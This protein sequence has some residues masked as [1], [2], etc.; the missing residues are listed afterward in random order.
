MIVALQLGRLTGAC[1]GPKLAA[2]LQ[3]TSGFQLVAGD[4]CQISVEFQDFARLDDL[5]SVGHDG[6]RCLGVGAVE[7]FLFRERM[8]GA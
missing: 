5:V 1:Q 2:T 4:L 8:D 7:H 3:H 6:E